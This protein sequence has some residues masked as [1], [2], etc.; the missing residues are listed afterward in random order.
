MLVTLGN[1]YNS[2]GIFD[3]AKELIEKA[4]RLYETVLQ[5]GTADHAEAL[6]AMGAVAV[7]L[8]DFERTAPYHA[9]AGNPPVAFPAVR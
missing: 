1:S 4:L 7:E 8:Q 5:K 6:A 3:R 9:R 2:L